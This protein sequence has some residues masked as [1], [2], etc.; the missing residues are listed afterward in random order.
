M[1]SVGL[2]RILIAVLFLLNAAHATIWYVHPDS[3]INTIQAGI[4]SSSTSD[5]V[6]V[7]D[8][9]YFEHIN[10]NG[11]SIVV[12]SLFLITGDT[13]YISSTIIDG[14]SSDNGPVVSFESGEDST[15]ITTGFTIQNGLTSAGGGGIRC[16]NS[17]P[18]LA[19]VKI[20]RNTA[21][22]DE[23]NT[24][25][26]GIYCDGS[27]LTLSHCTISDNSVYTFALGGGMDCYNS[28]LTISDCTIIQTIKKLQISVK[29]R[30][31]HTS[32]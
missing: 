5:T 32:T 22:A 29:Y 30:S 8:G 13:S 11:K 10:F 27:N 23:H 15:A 12:G 19:N 31:L 4:G 7:A 1:K 24:G 20:C 21:V 16:H 28:N 25:G 2:L 6:L 14:D 9:T 17:S 18:S 3:A 26:G